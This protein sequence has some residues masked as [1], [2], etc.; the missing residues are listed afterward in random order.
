[1]NKK[2]KTKQKNIKNIIQVVRRIDAVKNTANKVSNLNYGI[3]N[4]LRI[5]DG[6]VIDIKNFSL[7]SVPLEN[8]IA[9]NKGNNITI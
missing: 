9:W 3:S 8:E 5:Y 4:T 1:M 7:I 6:I 2:N